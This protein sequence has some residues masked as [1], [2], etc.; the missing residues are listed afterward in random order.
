MDIANLD[1]NDISIRLEAVGKRLEA[2][3]NLPSSKAV[4]PKGI[5]EAAD[6]SKEIASIQKELDVIGKELDTFKLN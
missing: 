1:T 6:I 4:S 5:A 3:R 2:W